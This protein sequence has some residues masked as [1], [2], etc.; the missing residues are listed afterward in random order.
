M[1][2]IVG[3]STKKPNVCLTLYNALTVLQHR[4]QDAAGMATSDEH[5][6]LCIHKDNGLVRDVFNEES[7]VHLSGNIG[8]GHTRY[9]TAGSYNY[10]EAQPF[11]V[12]SPYGIVLVHNGNIVN[13]EKLR[14]EIL[15]NDLRHLKTSSDSEVILNI[16][17]HA[18]EKNKS[19]TLTK[20]H[21]N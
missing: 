8:V 7:M 20:E 10:E 18:L 2:A 11:Y 19:L 13:V 1:C 14:D 5:G 17:A 6:H 15:N 21:K 16:F 4:G 12:N 9:P 3:V